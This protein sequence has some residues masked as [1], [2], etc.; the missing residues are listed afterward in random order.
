MKR[1]KPFPRF[2]FPAPPQPEPPP[3]P[4]EALRNRIGRFYSG[5]QTY[6]LIAVGI[7][8]ALAAVL[9]YDW[10]KPEPEQLSDRDVEQAVTR[11][12]EEAP[13]EPSFASVAYEVIRPSVVL[14]RTPGEE[15]QADRGSNGA[16]GTGVVIVDT[17]IILTALHVVM[18]AE[19]V[20]VVFADGS[21]SPAVVISRHPENDLAVLQAM[22]IPDD[23]VPA[24]MAGSGLLQ[25]GDEVAAV[26]HPFGISN[27]LSSGVVSGLGRTYIS[28]DTRMPLSNLIQFDAAVN[29]GNSGGP[30]INRDGEVV[31]I[32]TALVNPTEQE[33]FVGIGF[34]VTIETAGGLVGEP[35]W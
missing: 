35:V 11:L 3:S 31:G 24:T 22:V 20:L 2:S 34:A 27:S 10:I 21:E 8:S 14:V 7:V 9:V 17:G 32:V 12:L 6:I 4:W 30:L 28:P 1:A 25:V 13:P 5:H 23:L 16:V 33:F 18:D 29:P 15:P 19:T 26:G